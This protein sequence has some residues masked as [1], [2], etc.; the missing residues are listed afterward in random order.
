MPSSSLQ[1]LALGAERHSE[2]A[3]L[4]ARAFQEG[5]PYVRLFESA[6]RRS[7]ALPRVFGALVVLHGNHAQAFATLDQRQ[8]VGVSLWKPC[9]LSFG[10]PDYLRHGLLGL[11][12]VGL[13]RV[14]RMLRLDDEYKATL[15]EHADPSDLY[16]ST[17]GVLPGRQ[18]QG[19]GS[20]MLAEQLGASWALERTNWLWTHTDAN[21]R[22]Y[23][24]YGFSTVLR[25]DYPDPRGYTARLMRRPAGGMPPSAGR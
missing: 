3:A 22:L 7:Q 19:I 13:G 24:R 9:G 10:V 8:L 5:P 21:E 25:R 6:E 4:L 2:A 11:A 12:R 15:A 18:G 14:L 16:L 1:H 17:I 23:D 20:R